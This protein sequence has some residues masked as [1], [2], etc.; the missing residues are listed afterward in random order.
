MVRR[1]L[2][3]DPG[4]CPV[5]QVFEPVECLIDEPAQVNPE[6]TILVRE[7]TGYTDD[8]DPEFG[9]EPVVTGIAIQFTDPSEVDALARVTVAPGR[10]TMLYDGDVPVTAS[11]VAHSSFGPRY[12]V[13]SAV[14]V[15]DVLELELLT[16]EDADAG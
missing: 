1:L 10:A 9:W 11:A 8:G 4:Y 2:R 7:R 16:V 15:G 13:V 3:D 5:R 14:Q 6:L 12:R